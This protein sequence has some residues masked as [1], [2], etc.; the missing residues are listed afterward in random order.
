MENLSTRFQRI[1]SLVSSNYTLRQEILE[2]Q[3]SIRVALEPPRSSRDLRR[4]VSPGINMH[5]EFLIREIQRA[6]ELLISSTL[7]P[8]MTEADGSDS[9]DTESSGTSSDREDDD[10]LHFPIDD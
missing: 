6:M 2:V 9:E 10:G 4:G 7:V 8:A 1:Y 5:F 3:E